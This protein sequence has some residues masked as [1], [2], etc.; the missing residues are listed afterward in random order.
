MARGSASSGTQMKIAGQSP[1]SAQ[2]ATGNPAC[3]VFAIRLATRKDGAFT[4]PI[5]S[6]KPGTDTRNDR[7]SLPVASEAT[8]CSLSVDLGS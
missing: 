7:I 3:S 5:R 4:G 2:S 6:R 8:G 1:S